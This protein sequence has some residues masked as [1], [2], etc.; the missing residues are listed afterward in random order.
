MDIDDILAERGEMYG[1]FP[2]VA[3]TAQRIKAALEDGVSWH[4]MSDTERESA[5]NIASKLARI[6]NGKPHLDSWLDIGGY[7]KIG[8]DKDA[9]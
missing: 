3:R 4:L 5:H 8:P 2:N 6:V 1:E 9:K 7:S